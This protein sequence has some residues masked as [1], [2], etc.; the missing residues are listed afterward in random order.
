[1]L[2]LSPAL[3]EWSQGLRCS[4]LYPW[5]HF[6]GLLGLSSRIS[7]VTPA[8]SS[9][10]VQEYQQPW[11]RLQTAPL[12]QAGNEGTIWYFFLHLSSYRAHQTFCCYRDLNRT[13]IFTP[14]TCHGY[15]LSW[16]ISHPLWPKVMVRAACRPFWWDLR[17]ASASEMGSVTFCVLHC[18]FCTTNW[19]QIPQN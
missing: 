16:A 4:T 9:S 2:K 11:L 6:K 5:G 3:T 8:W 7:A 15:S 1:M 14:W 18:S 12:L 17:A 13:D 19:V 10:Q